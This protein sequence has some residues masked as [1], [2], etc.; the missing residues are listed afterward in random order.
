MKTEKFIYEVTNSAITNLPNNNEIS[1]EDTLSYNWEKCT[2][3]HDILS[4]DTYAD[5]IKLL[6]TI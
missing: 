3:S 1:L 4:S 6:S 5:F 2:K